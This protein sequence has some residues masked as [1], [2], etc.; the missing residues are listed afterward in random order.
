MHGVP[1]GFQI[2]CP[3][4]LSGLRSPKVK[5]KAQTRRTQA[6]DA[7]F[8]NMY[9]VHMVFYIVHAYMTSRVSYTHYVYIYHIHKT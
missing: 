5:A 6:H 4:F 1:L 3:S 8:P 2:L 7:V 9:N